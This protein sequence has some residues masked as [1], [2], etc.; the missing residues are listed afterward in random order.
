MY[1]PPARERQSPD[2]RLS[3]VARRSITSPPPRWR[4][5]LIESKPPHPRCFCKRVRKRLKTERLTFR[6]CERARKNIKTSSLKYRIFSEL[7]LQRN[8]V[9]LREIIFFVC[10]TCGL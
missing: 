8:I 5:S 2:W 1:R 3:P 7:P 10:N 9:I 6:D 4:T